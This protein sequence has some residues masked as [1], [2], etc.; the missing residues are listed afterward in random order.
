MI[1][2]LIDRLNIEDGTE[3]LHFASL[4]CQYG[5]FFPVTDTKNLT[6]KDDGTLYRFQVSIAALGGSQLLIAELFL[7]CLAPE[8]GLDNDVCVHESLRHHIALLKSCGARGKHFKVPNYIS[9]QEMFVFQIQCLRILSAQRVIGLSQ[10]GCGVLKRDWSVR[11][12]LVVI[13]NT[14]QTLALVR[15]YLQNL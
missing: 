8:G 5:Y 3:A 11:P 13:A 1:E 10:L 15:Q 2:W 6:V 4:L 14:R 9:R 12:F 7:V